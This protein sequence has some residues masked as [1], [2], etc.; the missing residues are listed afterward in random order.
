MWLVAF[1]FLSVIVLASPF[2]LWR[3]LVRLAREISIQPAL[4][5]CPACDL[6]CADKTAKE[7]TPLSLA[8]IMSA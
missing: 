2:T 1:S 6:Q 5:P 3:T 8:S 7:I 4:Q